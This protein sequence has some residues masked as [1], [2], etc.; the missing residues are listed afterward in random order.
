MFVMDISESFLK[1]F[2]ASHVPNRVSCDHFF[3]L[4]SN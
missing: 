3:D 4:N 2:T 1:D